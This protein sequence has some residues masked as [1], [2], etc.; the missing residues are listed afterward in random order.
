MSRSD[1]SGYPGVES[2]ITAASPG[3]RPLTSMAYIATLV[4]NPFDISRGSPESCEMST[5]SRPVM[6]SVCTDDGNVTANCN[7]DPAGDC[8]RQP[9]IKAAM[10]SATPNCRVMGHQRNELR[11]PSARGRSR[12][13]SS[14]PSFGQWSRDG[15]LAISDVLSQ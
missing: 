7:A 9:S 13:F 14:L 10:E 5:N 3:R 4:E 11:W 8:R 12:P 2:E 6:G 15:H 1:A